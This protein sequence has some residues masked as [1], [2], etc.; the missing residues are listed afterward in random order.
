MV[1]PII[2]LAYLPT[3]FCLIE[4]TMRYSQRV[5]PIAG[6]ILAMFFWGSSF[7]AMKIA[8]RD[9]APLHVIF[10]RLAIASCCFL[11][12]L[13][14]LRRQRVRPG[15][16]RYLGLMALF[17]PCLY[18]IFEALALEYTSASQAGMVT[19]ILPLMVAVI[20]ALWLKEHVTRAN[21]IGFLL[22]IAGV[23]WLSLGGEASAAAPNP[24]LGNFLEF[25]AM[26]CATGY[27][28]TLKRLTRHYSPLF[29][30][31]AQAAI[32]AL[33]FLPTLFLFPAPETLPRLSDGSTLAL[34]YLGTL[35]TVIAYGLYN[36]GVSRIP[37][38]QASAYINL[39]PV[40]AVI[41]GFTILGERFT[42]QQYLAT[43]VVFT[44]VVVSQWGS[45]STA[46]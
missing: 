24:L 31:A 35:V 39:I 45:R 7:I 14:R 8:F 9:F 15:D 43:L 5:I 10:W 23:W 32:G 18:F 33:F 41:L 13:P 27:I 17:E 21:I 29:L 16:W 4:R 12:I 3:T 38:S 25:I 40:F 2:L 37:V 44:G 22:A 42:N 20:A 36:F 19:A 34:I 46:P 6:L 28:I 26:V 1:H 11:L 30:T